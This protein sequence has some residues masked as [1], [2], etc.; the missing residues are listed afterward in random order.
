MRQLKRLSSV[1]TLMPQVLEEHED[2]EGSI[3]RTNFRQHGIHSKHLI[4]SEAN[5][6]PIKLSRQELSVEANQCSTWVC[7]HTT[8]EVTCGTSTPHNQYLSSTESFTADSQQYSS[9]MSGEPMASTQTCKQVES[10][11]SENCPIKNN[12][13]EESKLEGE[14][15]KPFLKSMAPDLTQ[16]SNAVDLEKGEIA[17]EISHTSSP[18][19][20]KVDVLPA[21][22]EQRAH[23]VPARVEAS[24][25]LVSQAQKGH[26]LSALE[27]NASQDE[28]ISDQSQTLIF[29]RF[30]SADELAA[31][32]II[33]CYFESLM[34]SA[35]K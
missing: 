12:E 30:S 32:Y 5:E 19:L 1:Q 10:S 34:G 18:D 31:R 35:M 23:S 16:T 11:L 24:E 27:T 9:L 29:G 3:Y 14:D 28:E 6:M 22:R 26:D 20:L 13:T 17:A 4:G 7:K 15:P 2:G 21:G 25:L 33:Y 8:T